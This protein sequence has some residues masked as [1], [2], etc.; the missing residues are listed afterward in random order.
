MT[1]ETVLK[2]TNLTKTFGSGRG[3]VHA[4]DGVS[5]EVRRGELV[6]IKGPSGAGKTTLL[7][8]L[9]GLMR[10][11]SGTVE[12][13]GDN[14]T[15]ASQARLADLRARKIGFVF[16]AYNL[17]AALDVEGNI[18][19]PTRLV[20][21]RFAAAKPQAEALIK[22][23]DLEH[24]RRARPDQLSGGEKQRVALARALINDPP[25]I[26]ADEPTGNLDSERG[27]EVAMLLHDIAKEDNR[28]VIIVTHDERIEDLAD[29]ILWLE[30]GKLRDRKTEPHEWTR[31]PVCG[32]RVDRW[33]A[34]IIA[35]YEG[36]NYAFC[37]QRCHDKF[38]ADPASYATGSREQST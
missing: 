37:T 28:A 16:Q 35:D 19:F 1:K 32:M 27:S 4:V 23:L 31:D 14:I 5:L 9:G 18:R 22:R 20:P 12:L 10:P 6:L 11:N 17:L 34:T 26:L 8:I 21:G 2:A 24:R 33:V 29:R 3:A 36:S 38:V 7:S 30:D 25:L 13:L 15:G